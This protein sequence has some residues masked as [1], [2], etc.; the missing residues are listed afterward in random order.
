MSVITARGDQAKENANKGKVDTKKIYLRLKDNQAHKVRVLGVKDYV[1]YNASGDYNLG[2]YNQPVAESSPLLVAHAK[3]GEKFNGLYKK[4]RYTFVFG[5]IETGELVAIDV[6]KNQAKTLISGIEEYAENIK[7]IAFNLKRTGAD[8]S[9]SYG[10]NP[11]LKM[12]PEDKVNFDKFEGVTV[13][14]EFFDDILQPKDDKFLAKLLNEAGF[15]VAT[16]LPH[17]QLDEEEAG[18]KEPDTSSEKIEDTD[19]SILDNI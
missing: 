11:I 3:G 15:D 5:S 16:H 12:K 10:L 7:E 4:Q 9:T 14:P 17:I 6:S 13:E 2:I 1:E 19:E 8:T 18:Q